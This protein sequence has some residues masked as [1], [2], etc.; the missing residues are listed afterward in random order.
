MCGRSGTDDSSKRCSVL[1]DLMCSERNLDDCQRVCVPIFPLF[2][3]LGNKLMYA[4][5]YL[6]Q[7][8]G[9]ENP[10]AGVELSCLWA[11]TG[12]PTGVGR[13]EGGREYSD[14][15]IEEKVKVSMRYTNTLIQTKATNISKEKKKKKGK[16]KHKKS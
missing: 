4:R 11:D 1:R 5:M 15:E 3:I 16:R 14:I 10:P 9:K 12:T 6:L 2:V 8:K 7:E 13:G